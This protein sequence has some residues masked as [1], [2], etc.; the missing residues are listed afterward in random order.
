MRRYLR[1]GL[2]TCLVAM[3]AC[4]LAL[5]YWLQAT[6]T[7]RDAVAEIVRAGGSV[8]YAG[9]DFPRRGTWVYFARE[10]WGRDAVDCVV[11]YSGQPDA[12]QSC[13]LA[14]K[15]L[16]WLRKVS[17]WSYEGTHLAQG[18]SLRKALQ[19]ALPNCDV[20]HFSFE[21]PPLSTT[22]GLGRRLDHSVVTQQI[23]DVPQSIPNFSTAGWPERAKSNLRTSCAERWARF[24]P[25]VQPDDELY[26]CN[27]WRGP[28]NWQRGFAL[29]RNGKVV[30]TFHTVRERLLVDGA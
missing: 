2:R 19:S 23:A 22:R 5:G 3:T 26:E 6:R 24:E 16:W 30:A 12:T 18:E 10:Q 27:L 13:I 17:I 9:D 21:F 20:E 15:K 1:F 8:K 7:Q 11:E 28:L 14:I 29:V 25:L 4:C